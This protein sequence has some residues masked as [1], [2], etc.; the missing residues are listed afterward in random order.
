MT[1]WER[2]G[3]VACDITWAAGRLAEPLP[4]LRPP[5]LD[6]PQPGDGV[7][8]ARQICEQVDTRSVG[9]GCTIRLRMPTA[10][11]LA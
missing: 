11:V 1:L 9:G 7:W 10:R 3:V 8:L 6:R 2:P 5:E 4:G